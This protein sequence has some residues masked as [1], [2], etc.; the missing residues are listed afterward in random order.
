MIRYVSVI[1]I[2]SA[3][4]TANGASHT[5]D[6]PAQIIGGS[7]MLPIRAVLESVGYNLSWD[8]STRTVTIST[9]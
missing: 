1:T 4:F 3:S 9:N 5:L 7:T 8:E 6:V 2:D